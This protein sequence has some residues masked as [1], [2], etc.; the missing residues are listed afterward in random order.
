MGCIGG[1]QT[2]VEGLEDITANMKLKKSASII[3]LVKHGIQWGVLG[4]H[5]WKVENSTLH[6]KDPI[7]RPRVASSCSCHRTNLYEY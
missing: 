7:R 2:L 4:S 5:E 1:I 3:I 6:N